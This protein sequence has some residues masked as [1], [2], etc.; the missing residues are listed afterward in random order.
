MNIQTPLK[1]IV[2]SLTLFL[3]C[4]YAAD[5][6][7]LN[8]VGFLTQASKIAV[9][10]NVASGEFWLMDAKTKK[11]VLRGPLSEAKAWDMAEET[12]KIADF[13]AFEKPGHYYIKVEGA[14]DSYPFEIGDKVYDAALIAATKA[15]YFNRASAALEPEYAGKFAR[16]AGH[17]DTIVY[18]HPQA[19]DSKRPV[20]TVLSSPKG[21]YDAGDYN[22]YIVN[23]GISMFTLLK[24]LEHYPE[25]FNELK[26]GIPESDNS[27]PDLLDEIMWNMDWMETMQDPNDGGVYHKLSTLRFTAAG[28]PQNQYQAR[29]MI[30]KSTAATLDFASVMALASRVIKP[31]EVHYPGASARYLAAAEKAW[32]WAQEHPKVMYIQ[33]DDVKTGAY[34]RAT[35]TLEDEWFWAGAELYVASGKKQF[36]KK[37]KL[38]ENPVVGEWGHV[39][40]LG[41][42]SI[43][44]DDRV[45][46][47]L[48]DD[49][50]TAIIKMAKT[51]V[52]EYWQSGYLV[53]M[54]K[55][56]FIWGS[57]SVALNKAM[58]LIY[59]SRF[60][61]D[62]DFEPAARSLLD[63]ILGRNPTGYS[64]VTGVGSKT[65]MHIHHRVS[66]TDGIDDPVPG[67]L[68]GGPQPGWQD[69]CKYPSRVPAK[70][71]ADDWCS[72]STNEIAINWNA[73]LVYV[74]AALR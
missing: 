69:K 42:F 45:S 54:T 7:H 52:R 72:Y 65:P 49:A 10:P 4:A 56:D 37:L 68:A 29:Y 34:S 47:S 51:I 67:F 59:A 74:L 62:K 32:S 5:P 2:L 61:Q 28:M 44:D 23:S 70:S 48:K 17:P 41:L 43:L 12:V 19:A 14:Q 39:G 15:Y 31:Y 6:I 73:P 60:E 3:S 58:I 50:R 71:Y 57:N 22:K 66:Y 40:I 21:W 46:A 8:Q 13:T 64:Y 18:M 25:T 35:E 55:K 53:P 11:E 38:P 63:Y 1:L 33:P 20:G 9:V 27:V 26:F 36:L 24:A 30:H 16:P